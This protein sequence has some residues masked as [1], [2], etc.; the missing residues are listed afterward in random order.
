MRLLIIDDNETSVKGIRDFCIEKKWESKIV[1]FEGAFYEILDFDPDII[2]L[3]WREDADKTDVG[4]DILDKIW[5]TAF[6]PIVLFTANS[7]IIDV[8]DKCKESNM[9]TVISKGDEAPVKDYL[10]EMAPFI[11]ELTSFG[12]Q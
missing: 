4:S 2:V 5:N 9:L 12:D 8:T 6:R 11:S 1:D 3:D 7:E 10:T